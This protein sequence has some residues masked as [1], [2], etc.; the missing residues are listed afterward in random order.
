M[1]DFC[2]LILQSRGYKIKMLLYLS[3]NEHK[4]IPRY[5]TFFDEHFQ[6]IQSTFSVGII[7]LI[8]QVW[9]KKKKLKKKK[10]KK[11]KKRKKKVKKNS[12]KNN[13]K[14]VVTTI[15][16]DLTLFNW[17]FVPWCSIPMDRTFSALE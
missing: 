17:I 12:K 9:N 14:Y 13:V 2:I 16:W 8:L 7:E 1:Q 15:E 10:K 6:R 11:R 3:S 5:D 4:S